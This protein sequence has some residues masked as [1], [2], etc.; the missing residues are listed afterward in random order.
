MAYY[1]CTVKFRFD[2]EDGVKFNSDSVRAYIRGDKDCKRPVELVVN[3]VD[4]V[5]DAPWVM[6]RK[7]FQAQAKMFDLVAQ[8]VFRNRVN[9]KAN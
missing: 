4:E 8:D 3:L 1:E 6:E 2:V 9:G 7:V 5:T